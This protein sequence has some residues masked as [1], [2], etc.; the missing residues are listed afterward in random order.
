MKIALVALAELTRG[1]REEIQGMEGLRQG[2][3][4]TSGPRRSEVSSNSHQNGDVAEAGVC[5]RSPGGDSWPVAWEEK[6]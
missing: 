2:P 1:E 3:R 4:W 6:A 5:Q